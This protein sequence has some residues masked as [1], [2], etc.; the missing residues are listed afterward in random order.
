MNLA[1]AAALQAAQVIVGPS[2]PYP[3]VTGALA[4]ARAGDT[5]RV[6]PGVYHEHLTIDRP[7][8]LLGAPGT[9]IDA[10][11]RAAVITVR[12]RAVIRGLVIRNSGTDQAREDAGIIA[13]QADSL[14]IEDNR[15]ED[16]L[17]GVYVKHSRWPVIRRNLITGRD[18]PAARRGDG[19]HLWYSHDGVIE[20]NQVRRTR[21][22]VIW[23]SNGTEVRGNVVRE[24]RYG[25]HYMNSASNRFS[26]N[27]FFDNEV[28][29]IVMYSENIVFRR[30]LFA[31]ARGPRG[32]GLA[33][34]GSDAILADDNVIVRNAIGIFLDNSPHRVGATNQ[35]RNN[36]VAYNDVAVSLLPSVRNNVFRDNQFVDNVQPVSVSGGGTALGNTWSGNYWSEYAGFDPDGDGVG[37]TPFVHDRLSDDLLARHPGLHLF[38][39]SLAVTALNTVSRVLPLLSP[40]PVVVDSVPRLRRRRP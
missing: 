11:G 4:A 6:S 26:D 34:K 5:I 14:V 20:D 18:L 16:V 40:E 35:F 33:L 27:R 1:V 17:F 22:V 23:F 25:L 12:A 7:V 10:D 3:T 15:L 37:N 31:N 8:V 9:V 24:G 36:V 38:H 29:A 13:L 32:I 2:G 21:D 39:A 30:N 19:I 28:G